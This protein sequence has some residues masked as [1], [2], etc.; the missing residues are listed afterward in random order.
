MVLEQMIAT[1]M[2]VEECA[3]YLGVSPKALAGWRHDKRGPAY[4]K[5][6]NKVRYRKADVDIWIRKKLTSTHDS[7]PLPV[8]GAFDP[9]V[10]KEPVA[11]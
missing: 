4:F 9:Q 11:A 3:A 7:E 5:I 6:G 8:T 10:Q 2:D 1:A